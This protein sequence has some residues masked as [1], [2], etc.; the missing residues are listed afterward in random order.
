MVELFT[1]EELVELLDKAQ[2]N[3]KA[4]ISPDWKRAY[5]DLAHA[6]SV[7]DAFMARRTVHEDQ[8]RV[9]HGRR[10]P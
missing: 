7:L 10:E 8:R 9:R 3:E 2:E 4:A 1:R 6:A 5:Q